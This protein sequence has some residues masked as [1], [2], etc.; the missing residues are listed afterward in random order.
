MQ[1]N[2]IFTSIA[3]ELKQEITVSFLASVKKHL[4]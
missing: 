4:F 3:S 1:V 2:Y